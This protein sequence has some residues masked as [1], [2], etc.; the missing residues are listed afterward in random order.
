[1]L[2]PELLSAQGIIPGNDVSR[3]ESQINNKKRAREDGSPG[4]SRSRSKIK[5]ELSGDARAKR[6]RVLQVSQG[7]VWFLRV[8]PNGLHARLSWMHW[9]LLNNQAHPSSVN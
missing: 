1:M 7:I 9:K 8:E 5:R 2:G 6:M 4:P 3:Q